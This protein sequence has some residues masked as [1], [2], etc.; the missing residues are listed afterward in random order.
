MI[1]HQETHPTLDVEGCFACRISSVSMDSSC[2]PNRRKDAARIN[3][4]ESRWDRDMAAYKRLRADGLQPNKIDGA[5]NV[6]KKAETAF[7][8]ESGHV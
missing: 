3:A 6:E 4:T 5:A 2:T 7:Q 8:V 1:K